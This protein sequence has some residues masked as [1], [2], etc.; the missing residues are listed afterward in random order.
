MRAILSICGP[1]LDFLLLFVPMFLGYFV[2]TRLVQLLLTGSPFCSLTLFCELF[3]FCML[4]Y[5]FTFFL[6][7]SQILLLKGKKIKLLVTARSALIRLYL[8][9]SS[10]D[11]QSLFPWKGTD[12]LLINEIT[13]KR[14][15]QASRNWKKT[16]LLTERL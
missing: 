13:N 12:I 5:S 6:N 10:K 1:L 2:S 16:F 3:H 4:V 15:S 9:P 8:L 11:L 7:E 14:N